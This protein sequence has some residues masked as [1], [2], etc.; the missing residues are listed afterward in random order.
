[1]HPNI[2]TIKKITVVD[3]QE[4]YCLLICVYIVGTY[5]SINDVKQ[6]V[7]LL[8]RPAYINL[9]TGGFILGILQ[10]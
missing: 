10:E 4:V 3:I 6:C 1:M 2:N 8:P 9:I 7:F 5:I